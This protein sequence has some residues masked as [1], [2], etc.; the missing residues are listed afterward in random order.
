MHRNVSLPWHDEVE[1]DKTQTQD[2]IETKRQKTERI[3][4]QRRERKQ[5]IETSISVLY[6]YVLA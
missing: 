2:E 5:F 6:L 4:M 3:A 1:T